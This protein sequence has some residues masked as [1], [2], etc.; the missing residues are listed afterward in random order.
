MSDDT[1]LD[2]DAAMIAAG[3][4][5]ARQVSPDAP[6]EAPRDR[7][8]SFIN[9]DELSVV[10]RLQFLATG[11]R[12]ATT[13][14]GAAITIWRDPSDH[15]AWVCAATLIVFT[16]WQTLRPPDLGRSSRTLSALVVLEI[17][18]TVTAA[19]VTG[20][21][22]SPYVLTPM[23]PLLLA[24]YAWASTRILGL[25]YA[26]LAI[27]G[28]L[29]VARRTNPESSRSGVLLGIVLLLCAVLGAFTRRLIDESSARH[30]AALEE[31]ARMTRANEMLVALHGL[32]QTLPSSLDLTEVTESMRV[33]LRELFAYSAL[34]VLVR[35]EV[36]ESWRTAVS[37]GVRTAETLTS[38]ELAPS[39]VLACN[40]Q[41][42]IAIAD[43]LVAGSQGC[44]PMARS[45]LYAALRARGGVVGLVAIEH[46]EPN[47]YGSSDCELLG[48]IS[49]AIALSLDNALWFARLRLFGAETERARIARDLHDRIAQ[50][51]A[52][53]SF[54]LERL[55]ESPRPPVTGELGDLRDVVRSVVTELRDTLYELRA[56]VSTHDDLV[57]V[58]QRY[59][60]RFERRTGL[61]VRFDH[62]VGQAPPVAVEQELWRI[63]QEALENAARH[64]RAETV[65]FEYHVQNG[66]I[67]LRVS[68][69][70]KGF[71]PRVS[72]GDHYGLVGIR[73]RAD[74]IGGAL[75][76]DSRLGRGTRIHVQLE[77]RT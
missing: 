30:S 46:R 28:L 49:G 26:G 9:F 11:A 74:A 7:V 72:V 5:D 66:R 58:A 48:S 69:N 13:A 33:R 61:A 44:A 62:S 34:T 38:N 27:V 47:H 18:L 16:L 64:A 54:E 70:G 32:A 57:T 53:V 41:T 22:E 63:A 51:L 77:V 14:I 20:G 35:D 25:A 8:G 1:G 6:H 52:Y 29:G 45:G 10:P 24:G 31:V 73:E 75:S 37:E 68:D 15:L 67:S 65:T 17:A 59:L 55:A 12:W 40:A 56:A 23:V 36:G 60:E 21:L 50:S 39:L 3:A 43:L 2:L 42:P 76:I 4:V 19:A 71:D